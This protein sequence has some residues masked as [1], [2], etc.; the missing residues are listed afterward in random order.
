MKDI[1]EPDS[2]WR[3]RDSNKEYIVVAIANS[4]STHKSYPTTI[5]YAD[6]STDELRA[7]SLASWHFSMRE[8]LNKE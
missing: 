1:P 5:V 2:E 3:H 8:I 6:L 7:K 4:K